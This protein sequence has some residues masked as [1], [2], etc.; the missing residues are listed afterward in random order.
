VEEA[1]EISTRSRIA[2]KSGTGKG[3]GGAGGGGGGG[4]GGVDEGEPNNNNKPR[5]SRRLNRPAENNP[6]E[7]KMDTA[8]ETESEN[9]DTE[10]NSSDDEVISQ[11]HS[12][13]T[14]CKKNV[15]PNSPSNIGEKQMLT[16]DEPTAE[17]LFPTSDDEESSV[18]LPNTEEILG[19]DET[20]IPET[21]DTADLPTTEDMNIEAMS[22]PPS[23]GREKE[24]T[25]PG[26]DQDAEVPTH[27]PKLTREIIEARVGSSNKEFTELYCEICEEDMDVE[28]TKNL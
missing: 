2:C 16:M 5:Q 11:A 1:G 21:I 19:T 23:P 9:L 3:D 22:T 14:P 17:D 13:G 18:L 8:N 24:T 28:E 7:E 4:G 10:A 20:R 26:V 25:I 6:S 15:G 12:Q 27:R